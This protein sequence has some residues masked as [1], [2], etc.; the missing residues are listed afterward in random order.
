MPFLLGDFLW[1][2]LEEAA[3]ENI[4]NKYLIVQC[5][6]TMATVMLHSVMPP[7]KY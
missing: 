2:P 6:N 1:V 7:V 5:L 4:Q 3:F